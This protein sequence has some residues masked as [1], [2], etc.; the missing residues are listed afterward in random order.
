MMY[1]KYILKL[2][3]LMLFL[4]L[5]TGNALAHKVTVFA[6]VEGDTVLGESKFSGGKKAQNSEIIV[7]DLNG[8]ELLRTRTNEKGEFSFPIPEKTAMRIELI[9]GMGHKAEW[10]IPL[11]DFGETVTAENTQVEKIDSSEPGA[12]SDSRQTAQ[13]TVN[14]DPVQLETIVEKAV[15]KA[16]NQKITPLTKMVADLEQKGPSMNEILGGIGYI[17]GLMGVAM[18]FSSRRKKQATS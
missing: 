3:C 4:I 16:L 17:F 12:K 6:W 1:R 9:A 5:S 18:Y 15:T 11:E 14:I 7:W 2:F 8:R 13:T 10:I